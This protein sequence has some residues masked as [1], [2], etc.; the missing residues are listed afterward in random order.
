MQAAGPLR[1]AGVR[2]GAQE[3]D[4]LVDGGRTLA[5]ELHDGLMT[6]W[7]ERV[8]RDPTAGVLP[9]VNDDEL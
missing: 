1:I 4:D 6:E 2:C 8:R 7:L 3:F 9:A 5:I